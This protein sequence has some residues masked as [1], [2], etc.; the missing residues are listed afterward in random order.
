MEKMN[1]S[2]RENFLVLLAQAGDKESLNRLLQIVQAP[3]FRYIY[4]L[5]GEQSLTE[6]VL[7]EVFLSIC[8]K[9]N[10]LREPELFQASVY[11]IATR[12]TFKQLKSEREWFEQIRDDET[13]Q[14]IPETERAE[15]FEPE[16]IE[17][18][19]QL[20]EKISPASRVVISLHYLQELTLRE[21]AEVLGISVGTVKS[22]L[23][24]GL[25]SLRE[26]FRG[27]N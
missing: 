21:T 11:R 13:L 27:E 16:F 20:L 2:K 17:R 7:Q 26:E 4:R 22:R 5:A 8:R 15:N 12:E 24:Y 19:P 6:D 25:E 10:F 9:I 18:L 1:F 23:N 14:A 3:L